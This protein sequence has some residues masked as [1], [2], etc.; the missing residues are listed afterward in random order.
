MLETF[1]YHAVVHFTDQSW[2][3]KT[4]YCIRCVMVCKMVLQTETQ[5]SHFR[6]RPWLLLTALKFPNWGRQ[7][8]RYFNVSSPA[9]HRDNNLNKLTYIIYS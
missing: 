2:I 9:S 5:K 7:T 4:V 1:G 8:Q 3:S 6:V